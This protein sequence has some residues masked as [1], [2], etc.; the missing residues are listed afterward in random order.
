MTNV[1]DGKYRFELKAGLDE[2]SKN[3]DLLVEA[4]GSKKEPIEAGER[5]ALAFVQQFVEGLIKPFPDPLE[6]SEALYDIMRTDPDRYGQV[7]RLA[8]KYG[9]HQG[10]HALTL[11]LSQ[12]FP[13][14]RLMVIATRDGMTLHSGLWNHEHDLLLD[15]NGVHSRDSLVAHWTGRMLGEPVYLKPVSQDDIIE[16]SNCDEEGLREAL[17]QFGALAT[18]MQANM[19]AL[20]T[21]PTYDDDELDEADECFPEP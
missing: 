6:D 13:D 19:E 7:M 2:A 18:Y 16:L 15:A 5:P 11:A 4:L 10:R 20:V 14:S 1:I 17:E 12:A 8:L 3:L 9:G 21:E